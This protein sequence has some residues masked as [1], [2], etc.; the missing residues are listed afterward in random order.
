M[1]FENGNNKSLL[2]N[3]YKF[4]KLTIWE[5]ENIPDVKR[6][7]EECKRKTIFTFEKEE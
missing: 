6:I 7:K 4:L 2:E 3:D 1:I 5:N